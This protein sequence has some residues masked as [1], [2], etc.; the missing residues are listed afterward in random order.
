MAPKKLY[1]VVANSEAIPWT[2]LF[3]GLIIL[4]QSATTV[5]TAVNHALR[6]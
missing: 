5:L 6:S 3:A 4:A 2:L 1:R